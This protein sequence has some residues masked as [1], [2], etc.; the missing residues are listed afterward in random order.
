VLAPDQRGRAQQAIANV[1]AGRVDVI[2]DNMASILPHAKAGRVR[3]LAVT[4]PK[5]SNAIP[6]LPSVDEAGVTG[7]DV[8][9]WSGFMFQ[10]AAPRAL[11]QR[12]NVEINKALLTQNVQE[13]FLAVGYTVGGGTPEQ[14]SNFI[15]DEIGKWGKVIKAAGIQ[16][17]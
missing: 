16:P 4:S 15:R 17:Q 6:E 7:F 5:R 10:A 1:T 3:G 2:I 8:R 9:P 12:L 11:V 13:K 14:F